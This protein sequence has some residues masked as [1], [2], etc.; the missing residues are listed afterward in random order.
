[1]FCARHVNEHRQELSIQLDNTM[2]EHNCIQEQSNQ[3]TINESTL[4]Q[5]DAWEKKSIDKIKQIADKTRADFLQ[6]YQNAHDQI[7]RECTELGKTLAIAHDQDDFSESNLN[8]WKKLLDNLQKQLDSTTKVNIV[9]DHRLTINL[10]KISH[11]IPSTNARFQP[12]PRMSTSHITMES[13][14]PQMVFNRREDPTASHNN[15]AQSNTPKLHS[16]NTKPPECW[17]PP[18]IL[19]KSIAFLNPVED[20][21]TLD[22][23]LIMEY[24]ID[25]VCGEKAKTNDSLHPGDI[26]DVELTRLS[27]IFDRE[28]Y[29]YVADLE[30]V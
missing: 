20:E 12:N 10:I 3:L 1:M 22:I 8:Q 16:N 14:S 24:I 26:E 4:K 19:T 30:L 25:Q 27:E 18:I 13:P 23:Y 5:I 15:I 6:W 9:E 2:Q 28:Y 11:N 7:K 21:R 17:N 29:G